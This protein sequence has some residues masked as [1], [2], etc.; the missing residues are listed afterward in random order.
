MSDLF[1]NHTV[2]FPTRWLK[3]RQPRLDLWHSFTVRK[4][5]KLATKLCLE[6]DKCSSDQPNRFFFLSCLLV[7]LDEV[8]GPHDEILV[9]SHFFGSSFVAVAHVLEISGFSVTKKSNI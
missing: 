3:C 7:G 9:I 5:S 2:G 4:I 1:R 6:S 8:A